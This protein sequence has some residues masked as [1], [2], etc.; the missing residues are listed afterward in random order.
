MRYEITR[1]Q[2]R[3]VHAA[4]RLKG[5][6]LSFRVFVRECGYQQVVNVSPKLAKILGRKLPKRR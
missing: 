1:K 4:E 5:E 2:A 3:N 6:R